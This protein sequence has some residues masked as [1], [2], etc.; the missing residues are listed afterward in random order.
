MVLVD[1]TFCDARQ[2]ALQMTSHIL[3]DWETLAV[4]RFKH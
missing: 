2:Q 1:N 3:S 4:V